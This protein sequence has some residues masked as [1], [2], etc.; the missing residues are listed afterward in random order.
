VNIEELAKVV[1][2]AKFAAESL[3]EAGEAASEPIE[4]LTESIQA[5]DHTFDELERLS[6][7]SVAAADRAQKNAQSA[8]AAAG[9][10][11]K[12][13]A[14]AHRRDF[15]AGVGVGVVGGW[16]VL[17]GVAATAYF[18]GDTVVAQI[19]NFGGSS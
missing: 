2:A 13:L 10:L 15:W 18:F 11:A 5:L 19:Q 17:V 16:L 12:Q 3:K 7:A 6:S 1:S 4:R 14:A 9:R 8:T